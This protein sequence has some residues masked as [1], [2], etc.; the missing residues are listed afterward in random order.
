VIRSGVMSA[1]RWT[2]ALLA[3]GAAACGD[4]QKPGRPDGHP[5][6]VDAPEIDAPP[7]A[8]PLATLAGTGLCADRACT[9]INPGI[10]EYAP[11]VSF[12]D[13][14]ATKRRWIYLPPGTKIDTSDMDHWVFPVGTKIWKEFTRDTVRV[15]TRL[16]MKQLAD[17]NAPGAWFYATY[18]WNATDDGTMAVTEGVRNANG[19]M[20]DIPTTS[21]CLACHNRLKPQRVL[22]FEAIQLDYDA[23]ANLTDLADLIAADLITVKPAG[24]SPYFPL[25]GTAVDAAALTY[26]HANCGH[27]HNPSSDVHDMTLLDLRLR[28]T[29][30]ATVAGTPTYATTVNQDAAIPYLDNGMTLTKLIIPQDPS[31]S[32]VIGRMNTTI[33]FRFMP[34][35]AVETVDPAGQTALLAWINSL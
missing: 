22:G 29:L 27:C 5:P 28:T 33:Q 34:N 19:T 15:E 30:L 4:N 11:R 10:R 1:P 7:D 32:A 14:T 12:W 25:P 21:D 13:D 23:P 24:A 16:I 17:D 26:F 3:A 2:L 35:V 31:H 20:H 6:P 9:Q 8:D 18:Q